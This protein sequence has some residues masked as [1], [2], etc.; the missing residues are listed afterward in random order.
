MNITMPRP[1]RNIIRTLRAHGYDAYIVGGCVRDA[2]LG[3]SPSDWDITTSAKPAQVKAIFNRTVDTGLKHGTVTVM[4]GKEGCEVTTFRIDGDYDDYRRPNEVTFTKNLREDLMRR[5]FTI[6]AMAYSDETGT[7]DLF[8]GIDDLRNGIIRCVGNPEDRFGEDALRMLRAVRFSGQL[9]FSVEENTLAAIDKLHDLI[10]NV[11]PERIQTELLKLMISDHPERFR[12]AYDTGLSSVFLPEFDRMMTTE[13]NNPHHCYTVGEHTLKALTFTPDNPVLRLTVL[14]HDIGKPDCRTTDEAGI[15]H[16]H[17][18][19]A[20][21]GEISSTILRRLKFDN[22][23]LRIVKVLIENHD[24]RF[25]NSLTTGRRHV[26]RAM[27]KIGPALFPYLL[28]VMY[29]DVSAQSDYLRSAKLQALVETRQ[30]YQ[31]ILADH[32]C[33]TLK[34]LAVDGNDLKDLGIREGKIIGAIL[35]AL[36]GIVLENPEKNDAAYLKQIAREIYTELT[37]QNHTR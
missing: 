10:R 33:L 25:N 24:I 22:R 29:A 17:G 7:I 32:D 18:H 36:L 8:G 4:D 20:K 34:E 13:Q 21:G 23:T 30:A 15:D 1:V 14:L 37:N 27:S 12:L 6:N 35:A 16:F 9:G 2:L 19:N 26:R 3:R 5:D 11:S 28:D 31:E